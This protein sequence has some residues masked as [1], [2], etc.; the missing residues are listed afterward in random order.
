MRWRCSARPTTSRSGSSR[1]AA[2]GRAS[3]AVAPTSAT[4]RQIGALTRHRRVVGR[5]R[6]A[7]GRGASSAWTRCATCARSGRW[8]AELTEIAQG[9]SRASSRSGSAALVARLTR[10]REASSSSCA[11]SRCWP[12]PASWSSTPAT[13]AASGAGPRRR[14]RAGA[15]DLRTL[16]LDLR[17][18]L[19]A[20][21]A[22]RSW[23]LTGVAKRPPGHRRG[24]Q[25]RRP[26]TAAS[27][28]ARS[29]ALAARRSA[30]AAAARTTSP[31]AAAPTPAAPA[32]RSAGSTAQCRRRP[33]PG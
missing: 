6:R 30:A 2:R 10:R 1:S 9:A 8:C 13:S 22:R 16:A 5:L 32:R 19:G 31:R 12:R 11:A 14:R 15:D 23:P 33:R 26:G 4:P 27:R 20:G 18:R 21:S 29:C 17:D 24:D 3:S 28:P 25:R 7:P